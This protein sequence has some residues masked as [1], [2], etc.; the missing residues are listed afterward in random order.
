MLTPNKKITLTTVKIFI[1]DNAENLFISHK[2]AFDGSIDGSRDADDKSFKKVEVGGERARTNGH[3]VPGAWFV[4]SSRDH[5]TYF[6]KDGYE[7]IEV[8]N[9]CGHFIIATNI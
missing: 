3:G 1:R 5:F 8:Y 7:G 6:K 4:G 9:C 2:S